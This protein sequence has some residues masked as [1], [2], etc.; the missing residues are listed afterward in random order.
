MCL[1]TTEYASQLRPSRSLSV[2]ARPVRRT[3]SNELDIRS[4]TG[5]DSMHD[6]L[7][8]AH[9][10]VSCSYEILSQSKYVLYENIN[11]FD[12]FLFAISFVYSDARHRATKITH[13]KHLIFKTQYNNTTSVVP[14]VR[15]LLT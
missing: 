11:V 10:L 12:A 8:R 1:L 4:R 14:E 3:E 5:Y 7:C 15:E 9:I 2:R 13:V 6:L